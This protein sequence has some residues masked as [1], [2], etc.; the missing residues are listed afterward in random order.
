MQILKNI[1]LNNINYY[2]VIELEYKQSENKLPVLRLK[3]YK[4]D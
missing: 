2:E 3:N 4:D 1:K